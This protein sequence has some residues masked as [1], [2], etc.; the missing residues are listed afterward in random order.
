MK[1][2]ITEKVKNERYTR[3]ELK[4]LIYAYIGNYIGSQLIILQ[5]LVKKKRWAT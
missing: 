4:A 2:K 5:T 3:Y 1:R